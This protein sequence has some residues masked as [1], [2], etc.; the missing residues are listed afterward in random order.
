M[1]RR[2]KV[3]AALLVALLLILLLAVDLSAA[4]LVGA[5]VICLLLPGLGWARKMHFADFGDTVALAI[6]LSVCMTVAVGT[7]MLLT[8]SWSL[9]WGLAALSGIYVAGFLPIRPLLDH[10]GAAIRLQTAKSTGGGGAWVQT[11]HA[12]TAMPAPVAVSASE[13]WLDWY[14]NL[15]GHSQEAA[16]AIERRLDARVRSGNRGTAVTETVTRD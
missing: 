15:E 16:A 6:V 7:T 1:R 11:H 5:L 4:R 10:A 12:A 8:R 14:A 2:T 13:P 3:L 9:G